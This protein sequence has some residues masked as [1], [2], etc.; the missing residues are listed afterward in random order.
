LTSSEYLS[1]KETGL[2]IN[3]AKCEVISCSPAPQ[4]PQF[5]NYICLEPDEAELL[6]APLFTGRK[7]DAALARSA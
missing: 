1:K 2:Q 5:T 7:M 3:V 6:G 4:T